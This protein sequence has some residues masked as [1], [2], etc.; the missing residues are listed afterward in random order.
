MKNLTYLPCDVLKP[1]INSFVISEAEQEDT[2]KVLPDTG[3]VI[4]FQYKG[5]LHKIDGDKSSAL[6]ISGITG[7]ADVSRTFRNSDIIG[8][9]LIFF[10]EAGASQFFRQP[11]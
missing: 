7:L 2:Y 4:G 8:T 5:R 1:F 3:L 6:T 11:L 10:R 9:V